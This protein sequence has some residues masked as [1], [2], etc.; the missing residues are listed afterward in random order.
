MKAINYIPNKLSLQEHPMS[1]LP[2]KTK[3]NKIQGPLWYELPTGDIPS[4]ACFL[5]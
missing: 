5:G 3:E 2:A 1:T 4:E